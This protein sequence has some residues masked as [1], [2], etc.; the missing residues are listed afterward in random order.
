MTDYFALLDEPRRPWFDSEALK[1][2]FTAL[3]TR[4]HPD[5]ARECEKAAAS[6]RYAELNAAYNCLREPKDRLA[7]LLECETG[8]ALKDVQR[9]PP[10]TMDIFMEVGQ[11]CRDVDSFFA[12]RANVI[13]PL[14]KVQC[15]Q[16]AMDWTD[17]LNALQKRVN[18]RRDSLVN[19]LRQLDL[20]WDSAPPVGSPKRV[21]ALPLERLEEIY[22]VMSYVSR[23]TA[24]IQE[25]IVQLS[26]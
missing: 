24:Q 21:A 10:G 11:S 19:E 1:A 7:H 3:S 12:E 16:K 18:E 15:F 5:H 26:L 13:S 6:Q 25:R 14:L 17:K 8:S 20:S 23:W 22:R 4:V 2:K 9:I